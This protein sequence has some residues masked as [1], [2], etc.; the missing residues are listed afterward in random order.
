MKRIMLVFAALVSFYA[1]L[2]ATG[3]IIGTGTH[4]SNDTPV[5]TYYNYSWSRSI[6]TK[7]E[8]NAAGLN[9][10][11]N[12]VTIG[13]QVSSTPANL[14]LES[15]T[16]YMRHTTEAVETAPYSGTAGFTLVYSGSITLMSAGWKVLDLNTPF[17]W[18]NTDNIEILWENR[19]GSYQDPYALFYHT[20]TA[21]NMTV[22]NYYDDNF[23]ITNGSL[24]AYRPNL[25]LYPLGSTGPEPP[26]LL[27]PPDGAVRM[28][29]LPTLEWNSGGGGPSGYRLYLGT[30]NPP[31]LIGDLGL[32]LTWTPA[33]NLAYSTP[34]YW[35]VV[36]Y[37]STGDAPGCPVWNFTTL[38]EW[39]ICAGTGS[40]LVPL[41]ILTPYDKSYCQVIYPK[42]NLTAAH[43]RISSVS[44]H[45]NAPA[46]NMNSNDIVLYLANTNRDVFTGPTDWVSLDSLTVVFSGHLDLSA[47]DRWIT[48][49]V[50]PRFDY[51]PTKN[52]VIALDENTEN[53]DSANPGMFYYTTLGTNEY[54]GIAGFTVEG[55]DVLPSDPYGTSWQV[56]PVSGYP[57]IWITTVDDIA[58]T[59]SYLPLLNTPRATYVHFEATITDNLGVLDPQIWIAH[60]PTATYEA[61]PLNHISGDLYGISYSGIWMGN[62]ISYYYTATDSEGNLTT[63]ATSSF[64]VQDPTWLRYTAATGSY[65][66]WPGYVWGPLNLYANPFW[67]SENK[68]KLNAVEGRTRYA[69]T[70]NIRVYA[71]TSSS[72][73][74][75]NMTLIYGPA[76]VSLP[77]TTT[78]TFDLSA[79]NIQIDSPYFLV[80]F[81]DMPTGNYWNRNSALIYGK[82][83]IIR[84]TGFYNSSSYG[85]WLVSAFVQTGD[86]IVLPAP[87]VSIT[88][89]ANGPFISWTAVPGAPYYTVESSDDPYNWDW[90]NGI[91][92]GNFTGTSFLYE[93]SGVYGRKYFRVIA[94]TSPPSKASAPAES[95]VAPPPDSAPEEARE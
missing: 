33:A 12:I 38:S 13:I 81:T 93:Q 45:W 10:A 41:P 31:P 77:G 1:L 48:I 23:P 50:S 67:G 72:P 39:D 60:L 5:N 78:L 75:S 68:L 15:Q 71:C 44:F 17:A 88:E 26:L 57:N 80:G 52:L 27:N 63:S 76:P 55:G 42:E 87:Q 14:L 89:S 9:A 24:S 79:E 30:T 65:I 73:N 16:I 91:W 46:D 29:V 69:T 92:E 20:I 62:Q 34:Y 83:Y 61:F 6:Y 35:Q 53:N 90:P 40:T 32:A 21:T 85:S 7:A 22:H 19:D 59:I 2:N 70:A 18:N 43:H 82:S 49:P 37:N 36:P 28:P 51:D 3:Y 11:D 4:T 54:N 74:W 95:A 84:G 66:G 8:I 25:K 56:A 86:G 58:P 94:T 47:G 64:Y